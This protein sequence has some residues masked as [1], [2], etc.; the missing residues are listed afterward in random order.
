VSQPGNDTAGLAV[1]AGRRLKH[2]A[3]GI[4]VVIWAA[5]VATARMTA[6]LVAR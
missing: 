3:A 1:S 5:T 4:C 2:F 6:H